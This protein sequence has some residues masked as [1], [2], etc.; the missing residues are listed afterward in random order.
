[1]TES[2]PWVL[3]GLGNPGAQYDTTRHNLGFLVVDRLAQRH[4][5]AVTRS[6]HQALWG[7]GKVAGHAVVLVKPQTFMNLSGDAV[8][9][10]ARFFQ[11]PP[12][13]T[14]V[15]CDDFSIALGSLR[16]R[17]KGSDGGH[18]GLKS[19]ISRLATQ[20][21]PRLRMGIGPLPPHYD[22]ADFVLSHFARS[23]RA[24][25]EAMVE[26]AADAVEC[27]LVQGLERASN[28]FNR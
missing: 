24:E 3:V 10:L 26:R 5:V 21:F 17:A 7:Q 20:E 8:Q 11:T 23:E 12:A 13:K 28:Q 6:K 25:V 1:V 14:L 15:I 2:T 18:N 19:L 16:F 4:Q 27:L 22:V 9:P